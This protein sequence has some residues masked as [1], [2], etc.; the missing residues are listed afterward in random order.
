MALVER[1]AGRSP[2][3]EKD[4]GPVLLGEIDVMYGPLEL[5]AAGERPRVVPSSRPRPTLSFRL[6]DEGFLELL[7]LLLKD[8]DALIAVQRCP[9]V[10]Y[11]AATICAAFFGP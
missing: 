9:D 8:D 10:R 6:F 4:A 11:A 5:V 2:A 1:F 3:P 7:A